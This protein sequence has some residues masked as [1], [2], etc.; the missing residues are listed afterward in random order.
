MISGTMRMLNAT[1]SL[2]LEEDGMPGNPWIVECSLQTEGGLGG[3][4]IKWGQHQWLRGPTAK[5]TFARACTWA[6][7]QMAQVTP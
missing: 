1:L 4:N 3:G 5:E 2:K 7:E 6:L